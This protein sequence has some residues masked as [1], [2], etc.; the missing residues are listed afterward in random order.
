V[1]GEE[2]TLGGGEKVLNAELRTPAPDFVEE[3]AA[4]IYLVLTATTRQVG[5][6]FG[7]GFPFAEEFEIGDEEAVVVGGNRVED[8]LNHV[9]DEPRSAPGHAGSTCCVSTRSAG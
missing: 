7:R 3:Y 4:E 9:V 2:V 5:N 6:G 1:R 8:V